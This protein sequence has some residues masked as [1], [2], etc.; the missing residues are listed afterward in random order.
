MNVPYYGHWLQLLLLVACRACN[1]GGCR[2]LGAESNV[3]VWPDEHR[4]GRNRRHTAGS[5]LTMKLTSGRLQG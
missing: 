2:T 4:H 3:C 1:A 5:N